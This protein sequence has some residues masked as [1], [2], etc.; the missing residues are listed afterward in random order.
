MVRL[1]SENPHQLII[2]HHH[3]H[4]LLLTNTQAGIHFQTLVYTVVEPNAAFATWN[5]AYSP[6]PYE[7]LP[8]SW[9][10]DG[11]DEE[12]EC[13]QVLVR[14]LHQDC[15][16]WSEKLNVDGIMAPLIRDVTLP[17]TQVPSQSVYSD[18][19]N[20][21]LPT[22][23]RSTSRKFDH[24]PSRWMDSLADGLSETVSP[25][26]VSPFASSG[27]PVYN[28]PEPMPFEHQSS[29][30]AYTSISHTLP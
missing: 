3:L 6:T 18:S 5:A 10:E 28:F 12:L 17:Q 19:S 2:I 26:W 20:H 4:R 9:E 24:M 16:L 25:V 29:M 7:A 1:V 13:F 21:V 22:S 30:V 11:V 27:S 8:Q 14:Q 15:K 23:A